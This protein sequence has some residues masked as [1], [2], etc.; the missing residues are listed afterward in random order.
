VKELRRN[1][2]DGVSFIGQSPED[3]LIRHFQH[4]TVLVHP[5][6]YEAFGMTL[7]EAM[8]CGTPVIATRVGGIP[9][10]LGDAGV[11]IRPKDPGAIANAVTGLL[12]NRNKYDRLR[13]DGRKRVERHF[14]WDSVSDRVSSLYERF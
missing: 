4:A 3:E 8:A 12:G 6:L 10:V 9:E 13:S 2:I 1:S 14:S 11:L 5:A 7:V